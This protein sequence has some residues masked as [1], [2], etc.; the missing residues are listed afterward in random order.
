MMPMPMESHT[1]DT[2]FT[3]PDDLQRHLY[4]ELQAVIG[5]DDVL[6][7]DEHGHFKGRI[8]DI[9]FKGR[10]DSVMSFRLDGKPVRDVVLTRWQKLLLDVGEVTVYQLAV[11]HLQFSSCGF[12][13]QRTLF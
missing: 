5:A 12:P 3:F 1:D 9:R 10:G 13:R 8:S 2:S 11:H 6:K 7:T 4:G